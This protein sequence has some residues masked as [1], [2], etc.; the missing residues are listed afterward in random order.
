MEEDDL[1]QEDFNQEQDLRRLLQRGP[2]IQGEGPKG[3]RLE[4]PGGHGMTSGVREPDRN[5]LGKGALGG[6]GKASMHKVSKGA[7][8]EPRSTR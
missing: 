7:A 5:H 1:L 3:R 6:R 8:S 2:Q 4:G